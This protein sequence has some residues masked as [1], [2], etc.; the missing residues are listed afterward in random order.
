MRRD[1][2]SWAKLLRLPNVIA[3]PIDVLMG[4]WIVAPWYLGTN[5]V[6]TS[7]VSMALYAFGVVL[8]DL[9]DR[10]A[11]QEAGRSRPLVEGTIAPMAAGIALAAL[12]V[13]AG[14]LAMMV[15]SGTLLVAGLL[16]LSVTAYNVSLKKGPFGPLS[17]GFCRALNVALG[18]SM[19]LPLPDQRLLL[20]P[21]AHLIYTIGITVIASLETGP[22]MASARMP[23]WTLLLGGLLLLGGISIDGVVLYL[24]AGPQFF[25]SGILLILLAM[26]LLRQLLLTMLKLE[27]K[28][29]GAMIGPSILGLAVLDVALL[30]ALAQIWQALVAIALLLVARLAAMRI[31][32]T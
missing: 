21:L 5:L 7:I 29:V 6:L 18:M 28:M 13:L 4:C 16:L 27:P 32:M 11:D 23:R 3:S 24:F 8:N 14:L 12:A 9:V 2:I 19:V 31:S 10:K 17:M 22:E 20:V 30:V 25:T 1:L 26:T 15:G